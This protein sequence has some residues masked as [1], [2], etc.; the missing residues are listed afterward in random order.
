M[1]GRVGD[2]ARKLVNRA[3]TDGWVGVKRHVYY[4]WRPWPMDDY[5]FM[6]AAE[7][8]LNI[9]G[10]VSLGQQ[11]PASVV[12]TPEAAIAFALYE[13]FEDLGVPATYKGWN[14]SAGDAYND[15]WTG[16]GARG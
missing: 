7:F 12:L 2:L 11:G 13:L 1:L 5:N 4:I 6:A 3:V 16:G 15:R 10:V 9:P 8:K 14:K